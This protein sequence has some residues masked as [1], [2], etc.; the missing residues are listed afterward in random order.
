MPEVL[1]CSQWS[2]FTNRG[3]ISIELSQI[4][5][6][7]IRL[8][9]E[10][11][12]MNEACGQLTI[13]EGSISLIST[14][15]VFT[16]DAW[17]DILGTSS[18]HQ[19]NGT[20]LNEGIIYDANETLSNF[21]LTNNGVIV[22]PLT[23][24]VQA[25]TA[26]SNALTLGSLA[27]VGNM[28]WQ[29]APGG[30][31]AG[32]YVPASN[33]L[34]V[35]ESAVSR[36]EIY[37]EIELD[38]TGCQETRWLA[39]KVPGGVLPPPPPPLLQTDEITDISWKLSPSPATEYVELSLA[40]GQGTLVRIQLVNQLGQVLFEGQSTGE[41]GGVYRVERPAGLVSGWYVLRVI[42]EE[43]LL[44]TEPIVWE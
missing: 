39:V 22:D 44:Y 2:D 9:N 33:S 34:V 15:S 40:A 3:D 16:N 20:F 11:Q 12:F 4:D 25:N 23:A 13:H 31:L 26:V 18:G 29:T 37:L 41:E 5:D 10:G 14:I 35:L 8:D 36:T 1:P 28:S 6:N 24:P 43:G 19:N 27:P 38:V 17:L 42:G 21:L 7:A 30:S 32:V